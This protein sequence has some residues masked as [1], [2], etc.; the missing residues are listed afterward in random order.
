[1]T[2]PDAGEKRA[3]V[4]EMFDRIAP[5]YDRLNRIIS[6]GLD[7]SWRKT[8][9]DLVGLGP[10]D[11]VVDLACGTGDLS[12]L[13]RARG[14][15]V[16]GVD[17]A[18][19]MLREARERG[20]DARFVQGDAALLPLR[21]AAATV[22]TSGFAL[23]N[24]VSLPEVF[25]EC[26]RVLVPGGRLA[27]IEVDRP[28][29]AFVR[30]GHSLYFDRIVPR[31]GGWLSDRAAYRYLPESTAYLPETSELLAMI[32]KAGFERIERTSLLLGAAQIVTAVRRSA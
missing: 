19:R 29:S 25:A 14:A 23:R 21:D 20:V 15:R 18:G 5:G 16:V 24:F 30:F 11:V 12:E 2:L 27:L 1:M 13:A 3:R 6:M 8:A 26:A 28:R 7:Q 4:Q 17:F 10:E 22:L 9:L 32:G 31:I